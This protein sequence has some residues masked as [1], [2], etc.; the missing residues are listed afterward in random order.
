MLKYLFT[1]LTALTFFG[2]CKKDNDGGT[3]PPP[4]QPFDVITTASL[5]NPTNGYYEPAYWLNEQKKSLESGG[6]DQ[7]FAYGIEKQGSDIYIA[8]AFANTK[9]TDDRL[10]PCFWKNGK[11]INLTDGLDIKTRSSASDLKWFN[12]ALY[13]SGE[14][15]LDPVLW[16][17][18]NGRL[19]YITRFGIA[20]DVLAIRKTGNMQV[21]NGKLYIG[22]SQKKNVNGNIVYTIG[23]WIIDE[24]DQLVFTVLHDNLPYA[25]CFSISVSGKGVFMI[26]EGGTVQ[27]PVPAI[28]T[29]A[30]Q[31]PVNHS[32]EADHHRLH[33][34]VADSKGNLLLNVLD[35]R[36]YQP[37]IWKISTAGTHELIKPSVPAGAQGF[38]KSLDISNDQLAYVYS[39]EKDQKSYAAY[40]FNGKTV[41]LDI[42]TTR[43]S[44]I[45]SLKLFPR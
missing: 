12:N 36:Q 31:H 4:P 9:G 44:S 7:A 1:V 24:H 10:K 5:F 19:E 3:P 6:A 34:G 18:K 17:V 20:G 38:C 30:G 41:E 2:S 45:H 37:V 22:G 8:G 28:W 32:F 11:K 33:T 21:Y 25:L 40:V 27:H 29:T 15:D 39:Y 23:Y 42:Y 43:L 13:I 14:A 26:G 35:T 16:K